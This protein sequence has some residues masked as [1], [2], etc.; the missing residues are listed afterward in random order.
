MIKLV[1][2]DRCFSKLEKR[3]RRV[4]LITPERRS[5]GVIDNALHLPEM[6]GMHSDAALGNEPLSPA[7]PAGQPP[8]PVSSASDNMNILARLEPIHVVPRDRC[9]TINDAFL[10]Y[11]RCDDNLLSP[12]VPETEPLKTSDSKATPD[13]QL[14]QLSPRSSNNAV[15]ANNSAGWYTTKDMPESIAQIKGLLDSIPDTSRLLSFP[16][17]EQPPAEVMNNNTNKHNTGMVCPPA[18]KK[19]RRKSTSIPR[20]CL[21]SQQDRENSEYI[22]V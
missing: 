21:P 15:K 13:P 3:F 10:T 14:R 11:S 9:I 19:H 22:N 5:H 18:P 2:F 4:R 12:P 7:V 6:A 20:R 17:E 16:R 8:E 1:D